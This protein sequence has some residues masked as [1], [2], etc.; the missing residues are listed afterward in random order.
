MT[1]LWLGLIRWFAIWRTA[2][3]EA[4]PQT[5]CHPERSE[6]ILTISVHPSVRHLNDQDP[7]SLRTNE[8]DMACRR[9]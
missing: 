8:F 5:I 4:Q 9:P 7:S 2:T 3:L 1:L 6:E